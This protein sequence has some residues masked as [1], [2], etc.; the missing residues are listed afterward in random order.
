MLTYTCIWTHVCDSHAHPVTLN[1]NVLSHA[2][3]Y[4]QTVLIV[5]QQQENVLIIQK[6]NL[7]RMHKKPRT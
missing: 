3:K 5:S 4:V 7:M 1:T 2:N 6:I